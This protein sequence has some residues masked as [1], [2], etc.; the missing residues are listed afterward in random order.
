MD[1]KSNERIVVESG[2]RG[3]D[4][5]PTHVARLEIRARNTGRYRQRGAYVM[6]DDRAA[7]A[8][9]DLLGLYRQGKL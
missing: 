4:M 7:W 2:S 3:L 9:D 1:L 6:N 5:R 8:V